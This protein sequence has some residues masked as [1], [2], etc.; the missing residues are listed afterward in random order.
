[1][2]SG[3]ETPIFVFLLLF[4]VILLD[5]SSLMSDL[6]LGIVGGLAFLARP[7]GALIIAVLFPLR[8]LFQLGKREIDRKRLLSFLIAGLLALVV[9]APWILYCLATTGH[10]LPDTFY[11]KV[12]PPTPDELAAWAFWWSIFLQGHIYL[13]IGF[14]LGSYILLRGKPYP[15]LIAL[16]L[17]ILY[18]LSAPYSAL[19]NNFRYL[20]P[21]FGFFYIAAFISVVWILETLLRTL[22]KVEKPDKARIDEDMI[23]KVA[24]VCGVSMLFIV[25][26]VPSYQFQADFFG[27]AVKNINEQQVNIGLWLQENTS[28]DAVLAIHDAG[29]LR[30]FSNRTIIDLAGLISPDITHG[31]RTR[32]AEIQYL[33]DHGCEYFVFFN[34]LFPQYGRYLVGAVD[35]LY[36]VHLTDNVI[37]GR[38]TMSVFF[39]NW[40][41]TDFS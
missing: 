28:E 36:T 32:E 34:E 26:T 41:L 12:H 13:V 24:L 21:V 37:S 17:S 18:R 22:K 33:H 8:F 7:E 16:G 40:S 1:M 38:D 4:S 27:N 25:Q 35:V 31:D 5:K 6:L 3:M 9:V 30:F 23:L 29:A 14:T 15:W 2:L 20:V 19:I 10:P 39:V 11:A